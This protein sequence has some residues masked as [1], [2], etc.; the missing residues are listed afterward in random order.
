[1][2]GFV[3]GTVTY[4]W[5]DGGG[6]VVVFEDHQAG[7]DLPDRPN[8]V[9][10]GRR[11]DGSTTRDVIAAGKRARCRVR[12]LARQGGY[13]WMF[14]LTSP[15]PV[16]TRGE[17]QRLAQDFFEGRR[18]DRPGGGAALFGGAYI[19]VLELHKGHGWHWHVLTNRRVDVGRVRVMWTAHLDSR[20]LLSESSKW[21][22]VHVK[23]FEQAR[24]AS[25]YASKYVTKAVECGELDG[26]HRY[27][28][29]DG[30]EEPCPSYGLE[31]GRDVWEV[32][33]RMGQE[34]SG[35]LWSTARLFKVECPGPP[36]VWVGW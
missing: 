9:H 21:A 15:R 32:A 7:S 34:S 20:G 26:H 10:H 23:E 27:T 3:F 24:S 11:E 2:T 19:L 30:V 5:P 33:L 6:E 13:R 18:H 16:R 12:R 1:M 4:D 22:R 17:A 36:V 29:G 8:R 28:L 25:A 35:A 14:T 31:L